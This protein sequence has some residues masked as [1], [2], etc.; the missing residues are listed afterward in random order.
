MFILLIF[1][2]DLWPRLDYESFRTLITTYVGEYLYLAHFDLIHHYL[3][4]S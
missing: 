2:D 3:F 4:N 1:E